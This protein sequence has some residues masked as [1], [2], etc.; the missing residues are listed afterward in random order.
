MRNLMCRTMGVHI[1]MIFLNTFRIGPLS[2]GHDRRARL[3][4]ANYLS[5]Q[6]DVQAN[7]KMQK[8]IKHFEKLENLEILEMCFSI[9]KS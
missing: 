3:K 1:Q 8:H 7:F 9:L 4:L 6:I 2:G 5:V